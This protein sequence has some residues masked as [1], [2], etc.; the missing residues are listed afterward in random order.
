MK[1]IGIAA[2]A[3]MSMSV[4]A[5]AVAQAPPQVNT[6]GMSASTS[7]KNAGTKKKPVPVSLIFDYKVGEK[8]NNRPAGVN[9][10]KIG[11]AG[12][13][14]DNSVVPTC[15]YA[16]IQQNQGDAKCPAKSLVGAGSITNTVGL[17][18]DPTSKA[19]TCKLDL[20]LRNQKGGMV[21]VLQSL[22][23]P[24]ARALPS[25]I[26]STAS[27]RTR[28]TRTGWASCPSWGRR[29]SCTRPRRPS[30]SR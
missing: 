28:A 13:L 29:V 16:E 27:S 22:P 14:A 21:L 7:P 5:I 12:I 3:A 25:T 30:R 4:A 24:H 20:R 10:Y 17:T 6:Y 1:K 15:S 2:I 11:F 26:R 19:A 8:N 9:E 18:S 23:A